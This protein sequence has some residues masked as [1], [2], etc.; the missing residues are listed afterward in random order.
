MVVRVTKKRDFRSS[1][2]PGGVR[3]RDGKLETAA[4]IKKRAREKK[5]GGR[6]EVVGG[7]EVLIK[8]KQPDVFEARSRTGDVV[9]S[10][11]RADITR[12]LA[13]KQQQE[14]RLRK[15][16]QITQQKKRKPVKQQIFTGVPSGTILATQL[17]ATRKKVSVGVPRKK[18]EGVVAESFIDI[19]PTKFDVKEFNRLKKAGVRKEVAVK[20]AAEVQNRKIR[21]V[22]KVEAISKRLNTFDDN[23]KRSVNSLLDKFKIS[24]KSFGGKATRLTVE[25]ISK[26]LNPIIV[27]TEI[28]GALEQFRTLREAGIIDTKKFLAK[29]ARASFDTGALST[30]VNFL[31]SPSKSKEKIRSDVVDLSVKAINGAKKNLNP[32][33]PEGLSN[34]LTVAVFVR[35][36]RFLVGASKK[37]INAVKAVSRSPKVKRAL[38]NAV[39]GPLIPLVGA[40]GGRVGKAIKTTKIAQKGRGTKVT[41]PQKKTGVGIRKAQ[42]QAITKARAQVQFQ[43]FPPKEVVGFKVTK[44]LKLKPIVKQ[45]TK[46]PSPVKRSIEAR[47]IVRKARRSE[48]KFKKAKGAIKIS[49]PTKGFVILQP[50]KKPIKLSKGTV[51]MRDIK[52]PKSSPKK[53][54]EKLK[55][56]SKDIGVS[57]NI[58]KTMSVLKSLYKTKKFTKL[59]SLL[60]KPIHA[61]KTFGIGKNSALEK[62]GKRMKSI[63]QFKKSQLESVLRTKGRFRKVEDLRPEKLFDDLIIPETQFLSKGFRPGVKDKMLAKVNILKSKLAK[64]KRIKFN[65]YLKEV[66]NILSNVNKRRF[67]VNKFLVALNNP[68]VLLEKNVLKSLLKSVPSLKFDNALRALALVNFKIDVVSDIAQI[69]ASVPIF[70]PKVSTITKQITISKVVKPKKPVKKPSKPR[71]GRKVKRPIGKPVKTVRKPVKRVVKKPVKVK[72]VVKKPKRPIRV[73]R[74]KFRSKKQ[75]RDFVVKELRKVSEEFRPSLV[76]VFFGLKGKKPEFITGTEIRLIIDEEVKKKKKKKSKKIK[77][78]KK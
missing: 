36:D 17:R 57:S 60:S 9:A 5:L 37:T 78:G 2:S 44:D 46:K 14:A 32:K 69:I 70:K 76:A 41:K 25:K 47:R 21:A 77:R 11:T 1:G 48:R 49:E 6:I 56:L 53:R 50:G 16:T 23:Y 59:D 24:R 33:T 67:E 71:K 38:S 75:V 68:N 62:F 40:G 45:V 18:L 3:R 58:N 19:S 30:V 13:R 35:P 34:I 4:T 29:T 39:K 12:E 8:T 74:P 10:G 54:K 31:K 20:R 51:K 27:G 66:N 28:G 72:R 26:F 52:F 22:K 43:K 65:A 63:D 55:V 7:R 61:S 15:I 73:L 64:E 42:K